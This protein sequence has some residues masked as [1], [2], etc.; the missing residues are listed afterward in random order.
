MGGGFI[1]FG[2]PCCFLLKVLGV[3][4]EN[5]WSN[6]KGSSRRVNNAI[7]TDHHT[8]VKKGLPNLI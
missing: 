4:V 8:I 5:G 1:L 3:K 6:I 7:L 2:N